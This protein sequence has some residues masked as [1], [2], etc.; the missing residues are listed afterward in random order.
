MNL[1]TSIKP[2]HPSRTS[3]T[4]LGL[5]SCLIFFI[6]L[7]LPL[8]IAGGVPYIVV[9]LLSLRQ[10]DQRLPIWT[11]IGCSLLT[12]LG[13]L[14]S[15]PGGDLWK[16]LANRTLALLAIW[17]TTIMGRL[18]LQQAGTIQQRDQTIQ[19]FMST[20]PLACFSFDR[21]GTILSWN[22]GAE[23]IYGYT[24]EEAIGSSS[25]DLIVTPE[26]QEDT[27]NVIEDVFQG[28]TFVNMIWHDR[29]KKGEQGW[30][31]GSLFPVFDIDGHIAYGVNFNIDITAQKTAETELQHKNALLQAI[32]DSPN[33][34]IYAKDRQ[35]KYVL[36]NK[37]AAEVVGKPLEAIIGFDDTRVFGQEAAKMLNQ[38]DEKV[39]A[40]NQPLNFE[41]S[42]EVNKTIKIFSSTKTPL[43]DPS[44]NIIGLVGIS[45]DITEHKRA[46][47]DL[48]LTDRVFRASRDHISI[49]G[50]D[51]QYRRVNPS[52]ERVHKKPSQAVVGMSVSD[53]L[54]KE[55]FT[56]TVKPMLDRCF[57]GEE[58]HYEAWFTF[59]DNQDH[60]MAISYLP[61]TLEN[62]DV[63]EIVVIG[64][65]L[66][67][68][69]QV[70]EALH[71][72]E[73]QLRTVL[74]AMTNFVGIGTVDGI[75]TDCNLTPLAMAGLTREDVIG[76]PF[77]DTYW[78]NYSPAVQEQVSHIIQRVSQG[79]FVREDIKARMG[80]NL[81]ITVDACY[82]PVK[83][84]NGQVVQ[85]VHS[86]IDVTARRHAEQ[87]LED[88]QR[89]MQAIMDHSPTLIFMKDLE[90]R[91]L[92]INKR[93]EQVFHV[94]KT[95]VIG[96]TDQE[97]FPSE[98][99]IQ[100]QRHDQLVLQGRAPM[101]VEETATHDDGLHTNLV[102]K[103]PLQ[104]PS[105]TVYGIGGIATDIT[106][107]KQIE[108]EL[109]ASE[110][111]FRSLVETAGSII[112]G[113]HANGWIAE[114]NR[115]AERLFGK[116]REEVLNKPYLN[117]FIQDSERPQIEANIRK[118]L[119]G[120]SSRDFQYPIISSGGQ[121]RQISWNVDRL[122]DSQQKPYGLICI[123]RDITEWK[124][125]QA[126]LQKWATIYQ[127]TQWGVAVGEP[128]SQTLDMV[129]EAY[130]RMHGYTVEELQGKP[131]SQVFAPEF[132]S[133]L[134]KIIQLIH[135]RG[136]HSFESL[137]I[138]KDGTTFPAF[139]TVSAIKDTVGMVLYRV[140][141]VIDISNQKQAEMELRESERRF[142][143]MFEQAA[144]GVAQ[145]ES[146]TGKF[147]KI[148]Q[149]YCDIVGYSQ[150]EMLTKTFQD[151][152]HPDDLQ[153][154]L[155]N[156]RKLVSKEITNFSREKRYVRKD[157]TMV[158][159]NLT[160]S[161][162]WLAD[163]E[164][165]HHITVVEDITK[166]KNLE[167]M[168]RRQNE[169]LEEKVQRRTERIQELE[170]RRMQVEK[171]AA[172]A[173]IAAGVAHEI[174]N[175]LASISQSLVLLK[176]AIPPEH[177]HFRYMA[178][179]E[180]CIDRI[181]EI[182]KHLYQL[183]RPSSPI[184][185]PIDLRVP[186]HTAR[187]IM[188]ERAQKHRI[189]IRISP[190][191]SPIT[192]SVPQGELTQVLC[193][194]IQNAIE[195]SPP[196]STIEINL[197]NEP[198]TVSIFVADQGEGIPQEA[199][200]HIF[201]PFFTT[202]QNHAEGGM[203]LG[204]SISHSLVESMGGILDFST[205]I[206]QGSTFRITFPSIST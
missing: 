172:L 27:K 204:L 135:E 60:Y 162:M 104:D 180:D 134:P 13:I 68:R 58:V 47:Q 51:Y 130:A 78:L 168:I 123:G 79:E 34:A 45:R 54:G 146:K 6:D 115:E 96:A 48:L 186:L 203:G 148:N 120:E 191:P 92:Q 184:P 100:F 95:K 108:T 107:R 173:Q 98:Q 2:P 160:V 12:I 32:L 14:L 83:D 19:N 62:Q 140:A 72:S 153:T 15:P 71:A 116:T 181:A 169:D 7:I 131:I 206:G 149:R 114:W 90:G 192:R 205:T 122:L 113:L 41:E 74:D 88:N 137:H 10:G 26:T 158:W 117:L 133:Q 151:I 106:P 69:K 128:N 28:K 132:R 29:N 165:S 118:V 102:H 55:V 188:G 53:L 103:F 25:Y 119:A 125:A 198:E 170:Q 159:I 61:L 141:N 190:I 80:E 177:P 193:N 44:G 11:A 50:R 127:H 202:K 35:G 145:I 1:Y 200:S 150:K 164:P 81:F 21:K 59:A 194:L 171:L 85:I 189:K 174:N 31:A 144:V 73:R 163:E 91:Y 182:T 176:R 195:A 43:K 56:Q 124:Q 63:Q 138:R 94:S 39:Y 196:E 36:F 110:Y 3:W 175:P 18:S 126:A 9:V 82:V 109:L 161:P 37:A 16:V 166:R 66:T 67:E 97:L 38:Y 112:I 33:D 65:D 154:D 197:A 75:V 156:M 121:L 139:L 167:N 40:K 64:R 155:D 183:Y 87:A 179:V 93:F 201:E 136:F 199:V 143:I 142:R 22:T 49:L 76:K 99:A 17:T 5:A 84:T 152:T 70:E 129:N 23:Q 89:K 24:N 157:G 77:I 8:G 30:R 52:Y 57:Q 101:E 178:K 42:L 105:G 86:G 187:E 4:I 20:V 111:R 46:Q 147:V 185:T